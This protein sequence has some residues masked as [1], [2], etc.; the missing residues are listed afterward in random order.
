MSDVFS[1]PTRAF[2]RWHGYPPAT[3]RNQSSS[4]H[5]RTPVRRASCPERTFVQ[6]AVDRGSNLS[7]GGKSPS[8][9]LRA[10][11]WKNASAHGRRTKVPAG[12]DGDAIE[13]RPAHAGHGLCDELAKRLYGLSNAR[14]TQTRQGRRG[15]RVA[16][17]PRHTL[18]TGKVHVRNRQG[19]RQEQA[20]HTSGTVQH[21]EGSR[22]AFDNDATPRA[23]HSR[24]LVD[25]LAGTGDSAKRFPSSKGEDAGSPRS[26]SPSEPSVPRA[27]PTAHLE[28]PIQN[29]HM[30]TIRLS[31]MIGRFCIG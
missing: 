16:E 11:S 26:S 31:G 19:T 15:P 10:F 22:S 4:E 2:S 13:T 21:M 28:P 20:R 25:E 18:G 30:E 9:N 27:S 29:S 24:R 8:Q 17:R 7:S 6:R 1:A 23:T 14:R 5:H 12:D 3:A